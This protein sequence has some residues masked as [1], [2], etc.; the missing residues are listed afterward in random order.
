M[1]TLV[2]VPA[3][4]SSPSSVLRRLSLGF[5]ATLVVA[6][7]AR[8]SFPLP[9]TPVPFTLQP[10]AVL[11]LGLALGPVDGFLAMLAYLTEGALGAP[12]FSP[13]GAGG[14][15]QLFGPTGGYL[16]AYPFV[17]LISGG[18]TRRLE[19]RVPTLAAALVG[20]ALATIL[21]FFC[22]AIWLAREAHLTTAAVWTAAVA[23]FLPGEAIKCLA[24]AGTFRALR[25]SATR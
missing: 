13:T 1:S 11:G 8:L 16:L 2:A 10:L 22:G 20:C 7:A 19:P 18:L 24:A 5:A 12:V 3:A 25:R 21:L 4:S 23:P 9:F 14:L 17:A 15:L 6:T